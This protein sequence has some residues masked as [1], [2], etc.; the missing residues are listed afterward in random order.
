LDDSPAAP[1]DYALSLAENGLF[2]NSSTRVGEQ[3]YGSDY[4]N[5]HQPDVTITQLKEGEVYGACTGSHVV[6]KEGGLVTGTEYFARVVAINNVGYGQTQAALS[7]QAPIVSPGKPTSVALSVVSSDSLQVVFNAPTD[8]GGD[9][10]TAYLVE[11]S[12]SSTFAEVDSSTVTYLD[13][14]APFYKT[15]SGL[16]AGVSYYVRVSAYNSQ[17]YGSEAASTP[18]NYNPMEEP[19]APT[20][21]ALGVTS[22]SM[23]TVSFDEPNDNGGDDIIS[24]F[25][26]W[27]TSSSFNSLSS[28]PNKGAAS[29]DA[30]E[31]NSYTISSLTENTVYYVR[32]SAVNDM[33]TGT[34][35]TT[36]PAS[37]FPTKQVPGKPHTVRCPR[38][39]PRAR[40]LSSGSTRACLPTASRARALR[41]TPTTAPPRWGRPL[42]R[43]R[44]AT[45]SRSTKSSTTKMRTSPG[46]TAGCRQPTAPRSPSR[47]S[48]RGARTTSACWR[49]TASAA[50][51]TAPWT[52]PTAYQ[53]GRRSPPRRCNKSCMVMVRGKNKKKK[54]KHKETKQKSEEKK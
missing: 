35:Q 53:P 48:P 45:S 21:V 29:I 14:G 25:V 34:S 28:A 33:G 15:I 51:T 26:E 37:T 50:A 44:A 32:V 8:D 19:G 16:T 9:D 12:T 31:H 49:A 54:E 4:S 11:W 5:R 13:G 10:I 22:D 41:R 7:S 36:S 47:V 24:Y 6:P 3:L 38:A 23:I 42:R 1:F 46:R 27:D 52:E 17:G 40:L 43:A 20:N 18:T 39:R 2:G 30:S